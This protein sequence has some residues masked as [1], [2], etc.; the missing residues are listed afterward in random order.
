MKILKF[1]NCSHLYSG[2]SERYANCRIFHFHHREYKHKCLQCKALGVGI[3]RKLIQLYK[4][5]AHTFVFLFPT[6]FLSHFSDCSKW[7]N[8]FIK[9][10]LYT[11]DK[12]SQGNRQ[13]FLTSR[14][15]L[16][17]QFMHIHTFFLFSLAIIL[18]QR[19]IVPEL[20]LRKSPVHIC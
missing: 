2:I 6:I 17:C 9:N 18:M 5:S 16:F 10:Q 11:T 20:V 15:Y 19:Y 8:N 13:D 3:L 14:K 1:Y 7:N 12:T 4:Y